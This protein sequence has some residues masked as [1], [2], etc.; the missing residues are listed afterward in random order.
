M[1]TPVNCVQKILKS[2]GYS[3]GVLLLAWLTFVGSGFYGLEFG[4]HWDED[5]SLRSVFQAYKTGHP[6]PGWYQY[7]SLLFTIGCVVNFLCSAWA[8]ITEL[9]ID[10]KLAWRGAM[11][12]LSSLSGFVVFDFVKSWRGDHKRALMTALVLLSSFELSYH[13]RWIAPDTLLLLFGMTTFCCLAR[14]VN[15]QKGSQKWYSLAAIA[16]GCACGSKYP[17][18]LF[19]LPLVS[20]VLFDS[21]LSELVAPRVRFAL[22]L[23]LIFS[24]TVLALTPGLIFDFTR[25]VTDI[26]YEMNH[27][28]TGHG[29]Y[30]VEPGTFHFAKIGQYL[31]GVF[32][33]Y[34]SIF[35][36][37]LAGFAVAG[38]FRSLIERSPLS[39]ALVA[40]FCLYAVY[41]SQQ[42]VMI[43]RN[44]LVLFPMVAIWVAE[45]VH[46]CLSR[47]KSFRGVG[48]II[49]VCL[50]AGFGANAYFIAVQSSV[51]RH[52]VPVQ[53]HWDKLS[54]EPGLEHHHF[55][56]NTQKEPTAKRRSIFIQK[57]KAGQ[58]EQILFRTD[59]TNETN[60][61]ANR[62]HI[63]RSLD[64][65]GEVNWSYY[66][67]WRGPARVLLVSPLIGEELRV[68]EPKR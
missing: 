46:W 47:L 25:A 34:F 1:F 7:P 67:T 64:G 52:R 9:V 68:W 35:A 63:Y 22:N 45:G 56:G 65:P 66:P 24:I 59:G 10:L 4:Y 15:A 3:Y 20:V 39:C 2:S 54:T 26:Q 23:S 43:V 28:A 27:Y 60:W 44:L 16:A 17:G 41:F 29:P 8:M 55:P 38:F 30:S 58:V 42:R 13:S 40:T 48:E 33:S 5:K 19:I 21:K 32:P 14:A 37:L 62:A 49:V 11:I 12:V 6:L 31:L 57:S 51:I 18:G 61:I 53:S 50:V 36:F